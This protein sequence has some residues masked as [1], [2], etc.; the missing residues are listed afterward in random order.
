MLKWVNAENRPEDLTRP[1]DVLTHLHV[2]YRKRGF[3]ER[4][5]LHE[6]HEKH[7]E[8]ADLKRAAEILGRRNDNGVYGSAALVHGS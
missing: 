3:P 7:P 8:H 6:E 2:E 4:H 5:P 1:P